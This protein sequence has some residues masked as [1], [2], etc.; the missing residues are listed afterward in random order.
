M[1]TKWMLPLA[2]ALIMS[3]TSVNSNAKEAMLAEVRMFAGNFAPRG[4]A[5]CHGQLLSIFQNTALFSILG[6]TYGGDGRTTFALPDLRGRAAVGVGQSPG[7]DNVTLGEK[8]GPETVTVSKSPTEDKGKKSGETQ[9]IEVKAP[10]LGMHYII[11]LQGIYPSR[12]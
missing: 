9:T 2:M 12:S 10:S 11:C 7:L 3:T 8:R 1:R 5:F 4:W 6:T